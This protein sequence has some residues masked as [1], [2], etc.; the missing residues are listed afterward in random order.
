MARFAYAE[1]G[2]LLPEEKRRRR[3]MSI[4]DFIAVGRG[5]PSVGGAFCPNAVV[6]VRADDDGVIPKGPGSGAPYSPAW[7]SMLQMTVPS[8]VP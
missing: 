6:G 3:A 8:K 2:S 1:E 5:L 7:C 4:V